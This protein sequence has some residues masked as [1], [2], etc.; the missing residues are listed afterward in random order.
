MLIIGS[1]CEIRFFFFF[2]GKNNNSHE[3][4][5]LSNYIYML[6]HVGFLISTM[7]VLNGFS[8]LYCFHFSFKIVPLSFP[9]VCRI[10][11]SSSC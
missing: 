11:C 7:S 5:K 3:F 2:C 6:E 9:G 4:H 1:Y 8:D 10:R